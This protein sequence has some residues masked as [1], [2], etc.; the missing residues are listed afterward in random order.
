[1]S[2]PEVELAIGFLMS[3]PDVRVYAERM[4][5]A[6]IHFGSANWQERLRWRLGLGPARWMVEAAADQFQLREGK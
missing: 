6:R 1:M 2:D 4:Q 5:R 3:S